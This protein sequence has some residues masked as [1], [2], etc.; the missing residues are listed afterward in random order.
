MKEPH[1]ARKN[2]KKG[3]LK[4]YSCFFFLYFF[5]EKLKYFFWQKK[6]DEHF[7]FHFFFSFFPFFS[8]FHFFFKKI[9]S[10]WFF[11]SKME[12]NGKT[13]LVFFW[14]VLFFLRFSSFFFAFFVLFLCFCVFV[15][16]YGFWLLV[17]GLGFLFFLLNLKKVKKNIF[18][19]CS[20]VGGGSLTALMGG[21]LCGF[22]VVSGS[23]GI[24]L[25]NL[26][27]N[28]LIYYLS[29]LIFFFL[30]GHFIWLFICSCGVGDSLGCLT[31]LQMWFLCYQCLLGYNTWLFTQ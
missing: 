18:F 17:F 19:F 26:S 2:A 5:W 16:V 23:L 21:C 13:V 20:C 31:E 1:L 12:K 7:F 27:N 30:V 22:C 3:K 11:V 10:R 6:K 25:D 28:L 29:S 4:F 24:I 15:L 8:F 14:F 9:F